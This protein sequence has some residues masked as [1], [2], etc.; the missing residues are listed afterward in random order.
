L[1]SL[2]T[3]DG[4]TLA[5]REQ[6]SGPPLLLHPGG[7]GGSSRYFGDLPELESERTLLLLDPRGTGDSDR[8]A[9][10]SGYGLDD[11]AADIE[12]LRE[13]LAL[14]RIDLLGHS[15]GGF[16]AMSWAG[17]H[18]DRVSHLALANT[19]PRFTDEIRQRRMERLESHRGQPYFDDAMEALEAHRQGRYSS[20][21]ELADLFRRDWRLQVAPEVDYGPIGEGL[22]KA[23]SNADALRHFNE[24]VAGRMDHRAHLERIA[25]PTLVLAAELD[26][27]AASAQETAD[28]LPDPTLV[29]LPGADH[30]TFL[31]KENRAAWSRAVVDFLAERT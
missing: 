7:P 30:F 8:P 17:D 11:Y 20:D 21:E 10:P 26:P 28:H 16:V 23:G 4:R 24:R 29:V 27:F 19:T 3:T 2:T 15:H 14:E 18:P 22:A 13:H 6:G 12:S 9:D 31:E 1:P 25:A 5:W